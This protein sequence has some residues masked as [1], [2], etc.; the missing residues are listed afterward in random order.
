MLAGTTVRWAQA[1]K[2]RDCYKYIVEVASGCLVL[3][4]SWNVSRPATLYTGAVK[5]GQTPI[6]VGAL[7]D[8]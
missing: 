2:W 1:V 6:G 7:C 3:G 8:E 4:C 5:P